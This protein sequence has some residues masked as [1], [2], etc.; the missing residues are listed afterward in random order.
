MALSMKVD[1]KLLFDVRLKHP[2]ETSRRIPRWIVYYSV[3]QRYFSWGMGNTLM[4]TSHGNL[5]SSE[6]QMGLLCLTK[7]TDIIIL[8]P[9]KGETKTIHVFGKRGE[10]LS[11]YL[12]YNRKSEK[13]KILAVKIFDDSWIEHWLIILGGQNKKLARSFQ[14]V[15]SNS[16]TQYMLNKIN[17]KITILIDA[18]RTLCH[19][20][21]NLE[22][23]VIYK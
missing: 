7:K 14:A 8:N 20:Y 18:Y 6:A 23:Y 5:G 17:N 10:S 16:M 19:L 13:A 22:H 12:D 1:L 21:I 15:G 3:P 11:G 4:T 2:P 9:T